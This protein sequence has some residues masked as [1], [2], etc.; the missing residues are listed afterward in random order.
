M[1]LN[2]P[3]LVLLVLI[4]LV[5][6]AITHPLEFPLK[7]LLHS[8]SN[9]ENIAGE[10]LSSDN[11]IS[12]TMTRHVR[13]HQSHSATRGLRRQLKKKKKGKG[14][15]GGGGE[16]SPGECCVCDGDKPNILILKY[17]PAGKTSLLQTGDKA[18]CRAGAYPAVTGIVV[19]DKDNKPI[20][21]FS[22]VTEGS[23]LTIEAPSGSTKFSSAT[24]FRFDTPLSGN[25]NPCFIHTSVSDGGPDSLDL[26]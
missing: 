6:P 11:D 15:S 5:L 12:Q 9:E 25:P 7:A 22:N 2:K 18:S 3:K 14:K 20:K 10:D 8:S 26:T 4:A 1:K 24:N 19:T 21:S 13:S 23:I 17:I 16:C